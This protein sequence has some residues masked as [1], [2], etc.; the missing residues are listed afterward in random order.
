MQPQRRD[1]RG[2]RDDSSGQPTELVVSETLRQ[3][4]RETVMG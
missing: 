3:E 4:P 1:G 2:E